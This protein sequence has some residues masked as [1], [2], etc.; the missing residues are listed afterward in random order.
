MRQILFA[1]GLFVLIG[2]GTPER[3][4]SGVISGTITYKDQPVNGAKLE[5]YPTGTKEPAFTLPVSQ[6]GTF[7]GDLQLG[8]FKVVVIGAKENEGAPSTKFMSPEEIAKNK[9]DLDR[10][11]TKATIPF[12]KKYSSIDSTDLTCTIDK[13]EKEIKLELKD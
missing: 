6:E 4:P 8:T 5:F 1:V 3:P 13:G 12:P 9:Q 11:K 2:C 7:R 10:F